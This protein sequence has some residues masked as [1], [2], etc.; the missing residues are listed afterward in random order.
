VAKSGGRWR[1][2]MRARRRDG[3][4]GQTDVSEQSERWRLID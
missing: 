3:G 4:A 2:A 1:R